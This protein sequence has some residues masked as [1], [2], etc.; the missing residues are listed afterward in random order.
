[1]TLPNWLQ[2]LPDA[3]QQRALDEWAIGELGIPGVELMERAGGGLA[4]LVM[5]RAPVGNVVV[6]CGKG[7]NGGDGLVVARLLRSQGRDVSVLLTGEPDG[8]RGDARTNLERLAGPA[9][10]PFSA[11]ALGRPAVIVDAILGTGF[12]GEP[13]GE[14]ATAIDAINGAR[15]ATV[16]ACDVPSGVDASTGEVS[17]AA[18]TAA[19]T[20]TF[21][22]GKPGLWI[23]P[24]K[25][26][27]GDVT[28]VNIGIP[29]GGPSDPSIGLINE[30]VSEGI[31]RRGRESTKFAAG[32]VLVCG[33]SIGLTG[34]PSMA[35][36]AAM[37]AGAGYVTACVPASL[38]LI[39]ETRLLE[40]MTVPVAD[41]D[42]RF[43]ADGAGQVLERTER[44]DSLVLGP[45]LGR[46]PETQSFAREVA[47]AARVPLLLDADG[48]NAH[49][50]ALE[51]LARRQAPTVLTP[52]AGE[53]ARLLETDSASI[54]AH[55]LD[56]V[57][58]AAT[59]GGAIVLLKGDD[60]LVAA[61]DGRVGVS[62]G[63]APALATAGTGDV[64]SGVIGALLSKKMDPF[65][66]ACAGA[67]VHAAAG[68]LAARHIGAEGVI[69]SDVIAALPGALAQG[70]RRGS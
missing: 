25:A 14:A 15:G 6:V 1:M 34:A 3:A 46:E 9:P 11:A 50:G 32:S 18:V 35:S 70:A 27:S 40:A 66:A 43:D 23:A 16:F 49:A 51:T 4:A 36:E 41:R 63:G 12:S 8:F 2:P 68:R 56:R 10:E 45:G 60:T 53:L 67:F 22:A 54:D 62:R 19:A 13:R 52:H 17:G 57:R 47:R 21:H 28:V 24:G 65:E 48:L 64:L 55:R 69:A 33:G 39:F 37:R 42:G 20:A 44:V 31:P 29:D 61:P 5:E 59:T 58:R 7:N 30:A 38:N 26:H